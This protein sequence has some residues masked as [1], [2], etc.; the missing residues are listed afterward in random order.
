MG[1][2]HWQW[3]KMVEH[4]TSKSTDGP[5]LETFDQQL[6]FRNAITFSFP[7]LKCG[8]LKIENDLSGA[9]GLGRDGGRP[10]LGGSGEGGARS[11]V[12]EQSQQR[13]RGAGKRHLEQS[14]R[15]AGE[16]CV[17]INKFGLLI[18]PIKPLSFC[19][20]SHLIEPRDFSG[21][22]VLLKASLSQTRGQSQVIKQYTT[23]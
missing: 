19:T 5:C 3:G 8:T 15:R 11:R 4:H 6:Y 7:V 9:R 21:K 23:L 2:W 22:N 18:A 20:D 17:W 13:K 12:Q 10:G 14:S 16:N 1:S